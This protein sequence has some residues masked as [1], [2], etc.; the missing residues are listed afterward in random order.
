MINWYIVA[1][2]KPKTDRTV[3]IAYKNGFV[4]FGKYET[5]S[6]EFTNQG[7]MSIDVNDVTH[8]AEMPA[9]PSEEPSFYEKYIKGEIPLDEID[10]YVEKWHKGTSEI[11]LVDYL[12]MPESLY[13]K[14]MQTA[15][16]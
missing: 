14:W 6:N 10:D 9:H 8:W 7:M 3:L 1:K 13:E 12:G 15:K 5:K 11:G 4:G 16:I 2:E